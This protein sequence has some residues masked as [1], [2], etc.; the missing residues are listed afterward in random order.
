VL[1][2]PIG[3]TEVIWL[4]DPVGHTITAWGIQATV[5]EFSKFGYLYL[6]KGRWEEQMIIP[7]H[8]IEESLS[9]VPDDVV[10]YGYQLWLLP[11]VKGYEKSN[12]PPGTFLA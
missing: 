9:P 11:A 12:I 4:D 7:E 1:F 10:H 3:L 5:R 2:K 8:W 6:R